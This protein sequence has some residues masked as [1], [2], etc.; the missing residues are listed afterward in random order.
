MAL[1]DPIENADRIRSGL[2]KLV[3]E[4]SV[5]FSAARRSLIAVFRGEPNV[6]QAG[7]IHLF[8]QFIYDN[9]GLAL[10]VTKQV[11]GCIKVYFA[12]DELIPEDRKEL[13]TLFESKAFGEI[14][15]ALDIAYIQFGPRIIRPK[16]QIQ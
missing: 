3:R 7:R 6:F 15:E 14:S 10:E 16:Q 1:F 11:S 5:E 4:G 13:V 8:Q 12:T 9:T 2:T